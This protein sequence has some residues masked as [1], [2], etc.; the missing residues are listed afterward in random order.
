ML[1][2]ILCMILGVMVLYMGLKNYLI[3]RSLDAMCKDMREH[4]QMETNTLLSCSTRNRYVKSL[5]SQINEELKELRRERLRY[6]NG[7]KE[8]KNAVVSISHDLRT[9]L[10]AICGYL[11][12]L[13]REAAGEQVRNYLDAIT[14]RAEAMKSLTEELFRYSI[15]LSVNKELKIEKTNLTAILEE[16]L[17]GMY[18][19]FI[20]RNI[21]PK[22]TTPEENVYCMANSDAM[23]RVI[24]N[25]LSNVQKYSEGD[26]DVL[27]TEAGTLRFSNTASKM[28]SLDVEKLFDRFYTVDNARNATG[29]GLSIAK[30]LTEEMGGEIS[31][32]YEDGRLTITLQMK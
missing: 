9:P 26:L 16:A 23:K 24:N 12:L 15:I 4:L 20:S 14:N 10:T 7:D 29:L 31:A 25:I 28:S 21:K 6:Q 2:W 32:S 8:L 11:E 30:Y 13:E 1:P 18:G 27:L 22:I 5:T 17:A 3:H 19:A